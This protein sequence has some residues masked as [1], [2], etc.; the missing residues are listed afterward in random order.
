LNLPNSITLL[1]IVSIPLLVAVLLSPSL[2][3]FRIAA[4]VLF[5]VIAI[6]DAVDGYFARK[7]GQVTTLGKFLDPLADKALVISALICLVELRTVPSVPVIIIIVRDLMASA[8]RMAASSKGKV[9]AAERMGKYKAAILDIAVIM[10]ILLMP[11][12]IQVLWVGVILA[13]V[14]AVDMTVKNKEVLRG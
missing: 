12:G 8:L 13:V 5:A 6:S 14:S 7:F 1:R 4:A 9:I 10:L 11:F 3:Q 2:P